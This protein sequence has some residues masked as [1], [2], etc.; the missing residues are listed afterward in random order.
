MTCCECGGFAF[1]KFC[2][3]LDGTLLFACLTCTLRLHYP[4]YL[5]ESFLHARPKI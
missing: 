5:P 4:L 2:R 1:T 3:L